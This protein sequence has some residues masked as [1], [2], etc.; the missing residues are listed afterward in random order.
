MRSG[1]FKNSA[2]RDRRHSVDSTWIDVKNVS[3]HKIYGLQIFSSFLEIFWKIQS[4]NSTK[5]ID[6]R[7]LS[8]ISHISGIS[9]FDFRLNNPD[10]GLL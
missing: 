6:V 5:Y 3:G 8:G 1:D 9:S 4:L 10:Y 7:Q 2:I